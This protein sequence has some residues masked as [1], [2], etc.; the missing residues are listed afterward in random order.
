MLENLK[1]QEFQCQRGK[2]TII[3]LFLLSVSVNMLAVF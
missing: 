2:E 1:M 3:Y